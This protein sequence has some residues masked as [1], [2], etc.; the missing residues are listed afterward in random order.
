MQ[1]ISWYVYFLPSKCLGLGLVLVLYSTMDTGLSHI[2]DISGKVAQAR[3]IDELKHSGQPIP[4]SACVD[5]T[6][7]LHAQ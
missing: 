2:L 5:L 7:W 6:C 3:V 1:T 4:G